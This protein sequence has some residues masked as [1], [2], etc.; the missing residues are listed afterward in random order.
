MSA[1]IIPLGLGGA[2]ACIAAT[3]T[4]YIIDTCGPH[5][6]RTYD[7]YSAGEAGE[8][9]VLLR[10]EGRWPLRFS[11]GTE[12]VRAIVSEIDVSGSQ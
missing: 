8:F 12:A 11:P 7:F 9:A 10:D 1:H 3:P 4:G 6:A 5:G 2:L